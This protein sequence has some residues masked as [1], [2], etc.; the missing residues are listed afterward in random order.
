MDIP[1]EVINVYFRDNPEFIVKH[2]LDSYNSFFYQQL[3]QIFK[4]NNPIRIRQEQD[5][6]TNQYKY[7]CN[8]Y[9]GGHDGTKLYFGK[10][11]IYGQDDNMHF[12]YPNE[13]RL[14]NMTYGLSI[15]YD[16]DVEFFVV[17]EEGER[18]KNTIT[19]PKIYLG[20]FPIMLQS[21]LCILNGLARNVRFNMGECKNDPGGYFIID[22]KEKVII[23]QEKFAN[24]TLNIRDKVNDIYSH[25]A[26]I[27]SVSED[28]S[29]PTRTLAIRIVAPTQSLTNNQIIVNIPNIRKPVPL[30]IVMRALGIISDKKIIKY[31]LLNIEDNS[32]YVSLFRPSIHDAGYIFTQQTAL[33][34][35]RLLTKQKTV[36]SV[37]NILSNYFLPHIGELNFQEKALYLGYMVK[38]LLLVYTKDEN[39]TNRDSYAYKR[40]EDSGMLIYQ[41]FREYYNLQWYDIYKRIDKEYFYHK[42]TYQGDNFQNLIT[43]NLSLI[44]SERIVEEGFRRAF[45]GNWG[46]QAHTK[47]L[48]VVQDLNRLS[49]FGF[50]SHL[51]KI[52]LPLPGDSAKIIAPRLLGA[53]QWGM[54][55]PIHTPDGGN[56]GLHKH[57]SI[58]SQITTGCSGQAII[59]WLRNVGL[60]LLTESTLSYLARTT[61][62]F[63]NGAWIGSHRDPQK[64]VNVIKV[65]RLNGLIPLYW[66]IYWHRERREILIWTDAGRLTRPVFYMYNNK[67]SFDTIIAKKKINDRELSWAECISGFGKKKKG[68]GKTASF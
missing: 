9:L 31:C 57:L 65:Y 46:A 56:V 63:V 50:I 29:K 49:Y 30:F 21:K 38:R 17:N 59:R 54:I 13:A 42:P 34:Y 37:L 15:H 22:G 39:P 51:R 44:F 12:M 19:I 32:Q 18:K 5:A 60:S 16:V 14:R 27:R 43:E 61:K 8:L 3:P 23:C 40:I 45:K 20:R 2:H 28:A 7:E 36:N 47:R 68:D 48:G 41:L 4:E 66:S 55:C 67:I 11:I 58:A 62:I 64:I 53:T 35:M 25:A 1:W 6:T 10:P 33:E 24:N 52:N 26:E